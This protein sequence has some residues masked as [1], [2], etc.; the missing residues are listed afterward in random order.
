MDKWQN[1]F[2]SGLNAPMKATPA[3]CAIA[4]I[5]FIGVFV[6]RE[7][8][9]ISLNDGNYSLT[10]TKH[11][12]LKHYNQ[13]NIDIVE[14]TAEIVFDYIVYNTASNEES[15]M[16]RKLIP[17][18]FES[19]DRYRSI[20]YGDEMTIFGKNEDTSFGPEMN[21]VNDIETKWLVSVGKTLE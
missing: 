9:V 20:V 4:V 2:L 3:V 17:L 6:Y 8:S 12:S 1:S 13:Q 14:N 21:S 7:Q 16:D 11:F 18:T 15:I 10:K 5:A 19:Q